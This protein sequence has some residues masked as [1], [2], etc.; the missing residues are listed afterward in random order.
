LNNSGSY[1]ISQMMNSDDGLQ[2]KKFVESEMLLPEEDESDTAP[3]EEQ[4]ISIEVYDNYKFDHVYDKSLPIT[5]VQ[6]TVLHT[7]EANKVVII[8]GSTGSGKTTQV[9]QYILDHY[10]QRRRYCN[11]LVT[12]PRRIAAMSVAKRVCEERKWPL[13]TLVG[14][15]VGRDRKVSEDT[16]ITYMTTGVLLQK[17][18]RNKNLGEY[19]H[20]L[21]DEV[22][23]R[24][25]DIDFAML[26]VRKFIR[27]V[28]KHVKV[29]LMSATVDSTLFSNYFSMLINGR[30]EGAPVLSVEGKMYNVAEYYFED[31]A[32]LAEA[33][34]LNIYEPEITE[35]NYR[36]CRELIMAL[37]KDELKD[38]YQPG[39]LGDTRGTVLCFLPGLPE[40]TEMHK[41]L[42]DI[43]GK[44][45]LKILPL[46]S[47]ITSAE[48]NKVFFPAAKCERKVILSTNLAESSITV[49][50]IKYVI[51]FCLTKSLET[52]S[53]T[54]YQRLTLQWAS[55]ASL[56]Q[57][58]G[59]AGRVSEGHCF[60]LISALFYNQLAEYCTPEML[61]SPLEQVILKVKLLEL[62]PPALTL[63]L[64]LQPPDTN[65][66]KRTI[67]MLKEVGALTVRQNGKINPL[68]GDLTFVGRVLGSLPVDV[69]IGKLL[70]IGY[71]FGC[72]EECL[73]I[74]GCLS[75]KSM[76]MR[77]FRDD[78]KSYSNKMHWSRHSSSDLLTSFNA[79]LSWKLKKLKTGFGEP[80]RKWATRNLLESRRFAE[81]DELATELKNRLYQFNIQTHRDIF[82]RDDLP[83]E[84]VMLLKLVIAGAFF[85]NYFESQEI[86]ESEAT[87][88]LSGQ[89]PFTTIVVHGAPPT[90]CHYRSRV[91]ALFR[92]CGIGKR[93]FF[94]NSRAFIEFEK[95]MDNE[96]PVST[97]VYKAIKMRQLRIP[98]SIHVSKKRD[99]AFRNTLANNPLESMNPETGLKSNRMNTGFDKEGKINMTMRGNLKQVKL[100]ESGYINFF[101]QEIVNVGHFWATYADEE[102]TQLMHRLH[103][104][105]NC[106]S[107]R[108]LK[109]LDHNDVKIG[110][111]CLAFFEDEYFRAEILS[112]AIHSVKVFFV[113]YGN[114]TNITDRSYLRKC[115]ESLQEIPFQA[116]ECYL[117][118]VRPVHGKWSEEALPFFATIAPVGEKQFIGKIYSQVHGA[119][120]LELFDAD[121]NIN[122]LII[123][124]GYATF[125]DE[126]KASKAKHEQSKNADG[127]TSKKEDGTAKYVQ[128]ISGDIHQDEEVLKITL[129]GPFSPYERSF[130]GMTAA[131]RLRSTRV[132]QDSVNSVVICEEPQD[133]HS[134][135]MISASINVS[136]RGDTM[137]A[138]ETTLLPNIHGITSLIPL[139][140]AP[141]AELRTNRAGTKYTGALCGLGC[142]RTGAAILPDHDIE[143]TFDTTFDTDDLL[144]INCLRFFINTA[145]G[146]EEEKIDIA[147]QKTTEIQK[148]SREKLL[149]LINKQREDIDPIQYKQEYRWK[150][151]PKENELVCGYE[152]KATSLYVYHRGIT[153]LE[154]EKKIDPRIAEYRNKLT[155]LHEQAGKSLIPFRSEVV[156]T[157]CQVRCPHPRA[158]YL[159]IETPAHQN[160]V[161]QFFKDV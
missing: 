18:I 77:P 97:A 81:I 95:N 102:T 119:Y 140:F 38:E 142:D 123:Q 156:C 21:L 161:K 63:Q 75:L 147:P 90:L 122:K 157:V 16:R 136:S 118:E 10:Q 24:D 4:P 139:L 107:G 130:F 138:R 48:Q 49:P 31:I 134:L 89:N 69:H 82:K 141:V 58:K 109:L 2:R 127:A 91:A 121:L 30:K 100:K 151:V 59:R 115:P 74:G 159:H 135:L 43:E 47:Q 114:T 73:I 61:R 19:T 154:E 62:G 42:A 40:I 103:T 152:E 25:Q 106:L 153:L 99:D 7:I 80:E 110:S 50:D 27:S 94:E 160:W 86:D 137:I 83:T 96:S 60:R 92:N 155:Q 111:F 98:L 145:I 68:D 14:Y 158:V 120:R 3:N 64:A 143:V 67:L 34:Q 131:A 32:S 70:L 79:F 146:I 101:I 116:F 23:E 46:H 5:D 12:Q 132:E 87:K 55:K 124:E 144:H 17:L 28:S 57:R 85:P 51:D 56:T 93:M 128:D 78:L 8:Q 117:S 33:P 11:I 26:V 54:N 148:H 35:K 29:V 13:G 108:N 44:R 36:L 15:Q 150:Q 53:E 45:N 22:H 76:F 20:V 65:D 9:A 125:C 39:V 149:K 105:I 88:T 133:K 112:C 66:I 129:R 84:D 126:P 6:E 52:D 72:L 71:A 37:D 1:Q 104:K 41:Y 113:D